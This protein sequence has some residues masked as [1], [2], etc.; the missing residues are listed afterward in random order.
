MSEYVPEGALM[1]SG[2]DVDET[3]AYFGITESSQI[4]LELENA[5]RFSSI[6]I[7]LNK[8]SDLLLTDTFDLDSGSNRLNVESGEIYYILTGPLKLI[9]L[10]NNLQDFLGLGLEG[11]MTKPN[12]SE[13]EFSSLE[14]LLDPITIL[15]IYAIGDV[16]GGN[17]ELA[18]YVFTFDEMIKNPEQNVSHLIQIQNDMSQILIETKN[19]QMPRPISILKSSK[20]ITPPKVNIPKITAP[21]VTTPE[22]NTPEVTTVENNTIAINNNLTN[23]TKLQKPEKLEKN[24]RIIRNYTE[25]TPLPRPN[26]DLIKKNNDK[27]NLIDLE[28]ES[29]NTKNWIKEDNIQLESEKTFTPPKITPKSK[30]IIKNTSTVNNT[31]EYIQSNQGKEILEKKSNSSPFVNLPKPIH[32]IGTRKNNNELKDIIRTFPNG[33]ICKKCNISLNTSWR[34][35][36]LCGFNSNLNL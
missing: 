13:S 16:T 7:V 30:P 18:K 22:V 9:E 19:M 34:F 2:I 26:I 5:D 20:E 24:K 1:P 23:P 35:C 31:R 4:L 14:K 29:I 12:I 28:K 36:P 17:K 32:K 15:K 6:A 11:N 27:K 25:A 10:T 3:A 8:I 33:Q 21:E